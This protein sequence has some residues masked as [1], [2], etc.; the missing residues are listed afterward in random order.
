MTTN[1]AKQQVRQIPGVLGCG[2]GPNRQ[3]YV[4]VMGLTPELR[5]AI[6][7]IV[8][9]IRRRRFRVWFANR[10]SNRLQR[11]RSR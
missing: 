1:Q 6:Y 9:S 10:A 3:F 7:R 2:T 8:R 11:R 5:D 4:Y